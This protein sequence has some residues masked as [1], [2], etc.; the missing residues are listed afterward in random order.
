MFFSKTFFYCLIFIFFTIFYTFINSG[1]LVFPVPFLCFENFSWSIDKNQVSDVKIWF[2]LWSKAGA[3]PNYIVEDRIH[4]ISNFNW[5]TNWI[6]EYFFNKMSDFLLG[7]IFLSLIVCFIFNEKKR[8]KNTNEGN[9]FLLYLMV[10]LLFL[11]WFFYHPTLRYG[12]YHLFAL[13]FLIPVSLYLSRTEIS[14]KKF[15]KKAT[16]MV[17]L[18]LVIFSGRNIYRLHKEYKIYNYNIFEDKKYHFIGG[19]KKIY[20]RYNTKMRNN[21][22]DY[23]YINFLGKKI[24][25]VSKKFNK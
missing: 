10:L 11:E 19:D 5:L 9:L 18:I 22:D 6:N 23:L 3:T 20:Y 25:N 2:E 16:I 15:I 7:L 13:I 14:Q 8:T 24:K 17:M 1:C 4:Y 12:G 21:L